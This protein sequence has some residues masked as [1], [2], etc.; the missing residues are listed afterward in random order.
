MNTK[1][2]E[3]SYSETI[4]SFIYRLELDNFEKEYRDHFK[5]YGFNQGEAYHVE[6]MVKQHGRT[7]YIARDLK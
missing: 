2:E 1:H 5:K 6:K 3:S 7:N 4:S